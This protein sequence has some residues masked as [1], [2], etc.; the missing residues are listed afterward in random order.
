MR[1]QKPI[2]VLMK[3]YYNLSQ[4]AQYS[5]HAAKQSLA[6]RTKSPSH[7]AKAAAKAKLSGSDSDGT[8]LW[9]PMP[10]C[11]C[12]ENPALKKKSDNKVGRCVSCCFMFIK[13]TYFQYCGCFVP[14][15]AFIIDYMLSLLQINTEQGTLGKV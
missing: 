10:R 4:S 13:C 3:E 9:L 5:Y 6:R 15:L 7:Q 8:P 12:D 1:S 2:L 14:R 11:M